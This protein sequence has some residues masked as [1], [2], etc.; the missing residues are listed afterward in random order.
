MSLH[1][2][3]FANRE[4]LELSV[5]GFIPADQADSACENPIALESTPVTKYVKSGKEVFVRLDLPFPRAK[6]LGG[7]GH[8]HFVLAAAD[9]FQDRPPRTNS[10]PEEVLALVGAFLGMQMDVRLTGVF[11]VPIDSLPPFIRYTATEMAFGDVQLRMT[12][13]T[14]SVRGAPIESIS[15]ELP[16]KGDLVDVILEAKTCLKFEEAYLDSALDI[17]EAAFA[18]LIVEEAKDEAAK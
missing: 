4:C 7:R 1:L 12:A 8:V 9:W 14:I 2:P 18:A 3:D 17:L 11:R 13:G 10:Q 15:W 6:E 16:T 5:C